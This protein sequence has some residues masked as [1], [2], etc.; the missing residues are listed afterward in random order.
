MI[1]IE[2]SSVIVLLAVAGTLFICS[3][4]RPLVMSGVLL[5]IFDVVIVLKVHP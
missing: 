3:K 2:T 4:I 5:I 1:S